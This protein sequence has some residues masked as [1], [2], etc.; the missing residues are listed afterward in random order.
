MLS[1]LCLSLLRTVHVSY[2]DAILYVQSA[3][4]PSGI[5][6]TTSI[7]CYLSEIL[8]ISAYVGAVVRQGLYGAVTLGSYWSHV[9]VAA[10]GD[11]CM[12]FYNPDLTELQFDHLK[13]EYKRHGLD[14]ISSKNFDSE[15]PEFCL[16]QILYDDKEMI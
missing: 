11:D 13:A 9:K 8:V 14:V 5:V 12:Y 16:R 15:Y 7:N 3:G 4:N 1:T 6:A 10:L 2:P